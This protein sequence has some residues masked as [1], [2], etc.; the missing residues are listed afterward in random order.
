M[1]KV[2]RPIRIGHIGQYGGGI[3]GNMHYA[4]WAIYFDHIA[5]IVLP[6]RPNGGNILKIWQLH[7]FIL[8]IAKACF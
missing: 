8:N 7:I 2:N 1:G 6:Y 4:N 5:D 3:L